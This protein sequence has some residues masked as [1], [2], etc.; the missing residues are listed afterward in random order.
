MIY[1]IKPGDKVCLTVEG[2][3]QLVEYWDLASLLLPEPKKGEKKKRKESSP[4]AL[5]SR[6]ISLYGWAYRTGTWPAGGDY[7]YDRARAILEDLLEDAA[8]KPELY[9]DLSA[10]AVQNLQELTALAT[11]SGDAT[12]AF[13][14]QAVVDHHALRSP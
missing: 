12:L 14:A 8:A 1:E 13:N 2:S 7:P 5:L 4:A 6:K 10:A 9:S 11:K 3:V